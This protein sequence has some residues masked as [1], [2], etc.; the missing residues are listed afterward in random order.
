MTT[1]P[2]PRHPRR[3]QQWLTHAG[4]YPQSRLLQYDRF[5]TAPVESLGGESSLSKAPT[6]KRCCCCC[7]LTVRLPHRR[8]WTLSRTSDELLCDAN[9]PAL[10]LPER[11]EW[12]ERPGQKRSIEVAPVRRRTPKNS[13]LAQEET[14]KTIVVI[15]VTCSHDHPI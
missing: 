15:E 5:E 10:C 7:C 6:G 1:L 9:P 3:Y 2:L 12:N 4:D 13:V 14:E 11:T 8:R